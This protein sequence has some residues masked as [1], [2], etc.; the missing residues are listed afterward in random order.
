MSDEGG[1]AR[2]LGTT[3]PGDQW[4]PNPVSKPAPGWYT[5]P[6]DHTRH[7]FWTGEAWS[8]ETFPNGPEP[9]PVGAT[10]PWTPPRS[11]AGPAVPPPAQLPP[12]RVPPAPPSTPPQRS[13]LPVRALVVALIVGLVLGF[14]TVEVVRA[15]H[16][17]NSS[18]AA[19]DPNGSFAPPT[20]P[21]LPPT[22]QPSA[23]TGPVASALAGLVL[24]QADVDASLS[25]QPLQGGDQVAG[26]TTLDICNGRFPSETLRVGRLQV[27]AV[28]DQGDT[29]MSTEAVAYRGSQATVQ[30]F[31]EL[32]AVAAA[33]PKDAVTS[34]VGEPTVA[35]RFGSA[36]DSAWPQT[37]GV[38]RLAFDLTT[39]DQSGQTQHSVA[40][41]LR[42]GRVLMGVYFPKATGP[43]PTIGSKTTQAAIVSL[44]AQRMRA[45]PASVVNG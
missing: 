40:V 19:T 28:D 1:W 29:A 23:P 25:V 20:S 8:A 9:P 30:A 31:S 6:V 42:R 34:P 14:S 36:P 33:C 7:R 4:S 21:T 3:P 10:S 45:L 22:S 41:Y 18:T 32:R 38:S 43:Q 13:P 27:V 26:E 35:T 5:D 15:V 37:P 24:H 39:T 11:E 12:A 16:T 17:D 2:P 44:F